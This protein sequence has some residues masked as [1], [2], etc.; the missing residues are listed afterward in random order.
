MNKIFLAVAVLSL[1]GCG[2]LL[3]SATTG[4]TLIPLEGT[5]P[6]KEGFEERKSIVVVPFAGDYGSEAVQAF[7]QEASQGHD[8]EVGDGAGDGVVF[9]GEVEVAYNVS[10]RSDG[11][12]DETCT[13]SIELT[14]DEDGAPMIERMTFD[15]SS[16]EI[17]Q[18]GSQRL[19]EQ[20][21][22]TKAA[23][24]LGGA[25][26]RTLLP[27]E[28][29]GTLQLKKISNGDAKKH[30]KRAEELAG[31]DDF[32]GTAAA[33]ED[34]TRVES[35]DARD[36]AWAH[37]NFA[38]MNVFLRRYAVCLEELDKARPEIGDDQ[39]FATVDGM[40]KQGQESGQ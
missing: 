2:Q 16:G 4:N 32:E 36:R 10:S 37:F 25:A 3:Y 6:P 31:A 12:Q 35:L 27:S 1:A 21:L 39:L 15:A 38:Y 40:C 24:A 26:G 17:I 20:L 8:V 33:L 34:A 23:R 9:Q 30:M 11:A 19:G 22:C 28:I 5:I 14:A 29:E 18:P 13:A 7:Q